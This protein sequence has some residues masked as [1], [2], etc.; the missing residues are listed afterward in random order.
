MRETAQGP[1]DDQALTDACVC[2]YTPV[3]D[4]D[5]DSV[6]YLRRCGRCHQTWYSLHC[7]HD[8]VQGQ[9]R[10][11]GARGPEWRGVGA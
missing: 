6:H 8:G 1:V 5:T 3:D 10:A 11:C 7:P 9:C 4:E 2:T